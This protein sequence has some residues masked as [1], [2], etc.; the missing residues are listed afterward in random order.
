MAVSH[1]RCLMLDFH[2]HSVFSDGE[3]IPAELIR[4]AQDKGYRAMAITDHADPSNLDLIIPH[5]CKACQRI[6]EVTG[7]PA[8]PGVEITHCPPNMIANLSAEARSLGAV[9]VLVHGET[10]VE[11]VMP[12]TNLAA[13]EAGVDI[14]A[15]PGLISEA[16]SHLAARNGVLLEITTRR[17][18]SLANGHV[19]RMAKLTGASLILNTD[20]HSPG[21]LV[22]RDMATKIAEGAGLDRREISLLFA[23]GERLLSELKKRARWF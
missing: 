4:R 16:T 3:L 20:S 2:T 6:Y 14:L 1:V 18:H 8:F 5:L 13:I 7:F 11:P 21:D 12:G 22:D 23:N 17:G 15:H 9:I 19:A 10:I